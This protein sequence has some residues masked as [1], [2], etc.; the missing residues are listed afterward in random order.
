MKRKQT[1][2]EQIHGYW[3]KA[4]CKEDEMGEEDQLHDDEW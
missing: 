3:E 2:R 1:H 4:S